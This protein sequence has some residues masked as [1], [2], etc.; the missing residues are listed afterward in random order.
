M[1][2][3][4]AEI[5]RDRFRRV[6]A[7]IDANLDQ[8]LALERLCDIAAFSKFHFQRQFATLFG[9]SPHGYIQLCRLK[10]AAYLLAF[11]AIPVAEIALTCGYEGPES[12]ARAFR[13][14]AGQSPSEFRKAPRWGNWNSQ[15]Q[16]LNALRDNQ[17]KSEGKQKRVEIVAFA[18]T[19]VAALEHRG[20]PRMIGNTVRKFIEWRKQQKLS[21]VVSATFN[22]VYDDPQQVAAEDYRLDICAATERYVE[23]NAYGVVGKII[24]AGRC[25]VLRHTRSDDGLGEAVKYLYSEWLPQSGE[26]LRD[27]RSISSA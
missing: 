21:P 7:Y 18:E 16:L 12:F 13:R 1:T 26:E 4:K 25:A 2:E 17:V 20:D 6:I 27:F 14:C 8:K 15:Y 11:R 23:E 19:K 22:I 9:I 3:L 5:Y 10:R 24:P